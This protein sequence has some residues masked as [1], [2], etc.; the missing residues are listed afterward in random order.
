M[1]KS[2]IF[3][4]TDKL[5]YDKEIIKYEEYEFTPSVNSNLNSGEIRIF[6]ENSDSL[7]HPHESYLE[8]EGRLV[9]ADGTAYAN[10]SAITLTHN[11][12]MHLFDRIEYKFYDSVVESVYFPGKATTMLG[13][14][15]YPNDFQLSKAMNQL[16]FK[17]T[18]ATAD[19]VNNSGFLARQ[20]FIIQKPTTKGK[21]EFS[22]PLRHIFGFCEDYDK[23]FYRLKH[24]LYM[25]RASDDNAIFRAAGVAA[26]KVDITRISLMMRRATPSAVADLELSK[27]IKS[28]ETLDIG[29]RSR[30]LNKINVTP[31][32]T[33]ID[34]DLR[35]RTTEKPRYILAGFQT[36]REGNQEQNASIF[37]H[38]DLRNMWIE[39]NEERYPATNYNLSFPNMKITRAYRHAANFA[40]DYYNMTNLISLC[41]ITPSDYKDLYPIMYFNVSKQSERMKDSTVNIKLKAEFNTPV[42]A[43]TVLFVLIISDRLAKITSNGNKLRFEY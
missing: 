5:R 11:G 22:I 29:F 4:I 36:N 27:I 34:C 9:K 21:F 25:L 10:D 2:D 33:S 15:K 35:V 26:G 24:E 18:T 30:F 41:N 39:F 37:D 16:W 28:Q 1:V 42:P 6:I 32:N 40:E 3:N 19:L 13:M 12:L 17:D 8:I 14:L 31:Q 7:F 43:N 38:C 23:I 20:Q